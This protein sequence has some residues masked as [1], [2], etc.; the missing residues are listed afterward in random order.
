MGSSLERRRGAGTA[1]LVRAPAGGDS[2]RAAAVPQA[3][4]VPGIEFRPAAPRLV[5]ERFGIRLRVRPTGAD[6]TE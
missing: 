5:W 3:L 1:M 2:K 4:E 6:L